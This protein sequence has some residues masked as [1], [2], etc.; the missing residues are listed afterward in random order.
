MLSISRFLPPCVN[1]VGLNTVNKVRTFVGQKPIN[2]YKL[3]SKS[4]KVEVAD[5]FKSKLPILENATTMDVVRIG[6]KTDSCFKRLVVSLYDENKKLLQRLYSDN[7]VLTKVRKYEID[8]FDEYRKITTEKFSA[9]NRFK[10]ISRVVENIKKETILKKFKGIFPTRLYV[11]RCEYDSTLKN[12]LVTFLKTHRTV[13]ETPEN[14]KFVSG[15]IVKTSDGVNLVNLKK[16]DN[17]D[18][19][20]SDKYLKYRFLNP[21]SVEGLETYTRDLLKE[22]GLDKLGID[23]YPTTKMGAHGEFCSPLGCIGYNRDFSA[24]MSTY[25]SASAINTAAHEVEHAYQHAKIGRIGKGR[26]SYEIRA[27][28]ELGEITNMEER[29][30]A[31][32]YSIASEKYPT[33]NV[34]S[35]NPDYYY[36]Y[37]EIKARE[38]GEKAEKEYRNN[39]ENYYFFRHFND[40]Y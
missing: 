9:D 23:I 5:A 10:P 14:K 39:F 40:T 17:L 30:E 29:A 21:K 25:T 34:N 24:P 16:S 37:L 19:D 33:K 32:K 27:M 31:L 3:L 20:F 1:R 13:L 12:P 28:Q 8:D 26:T 35:D 22:K 7:G 6:K 15:R 38:A 36:N 11:K 18:I 4:S 2:D